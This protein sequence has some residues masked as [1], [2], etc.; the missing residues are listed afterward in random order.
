MT[1]E[2]CPLLVKVSIPDLNNETL[3]SLRVLG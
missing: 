2:E 3:L 1:N